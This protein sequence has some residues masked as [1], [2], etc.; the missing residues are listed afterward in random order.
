MCLFYNFSPVIG[1]QWETVFYFNLAK[2]GFAPNPILWT[3][4]SWSKFNNIFPIY[5]IHKVYWFL[6]V[7][8]VSILCKLIYYE[9]FLQ[10]IYKLTLQK[11][12]IDHDIDD[13]TLYK[14]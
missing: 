3:C 7:P 5:S 4:L 11:I 8:V 2:E 14:C 1:K 9:Y 13:L 12:I 6:F 10:I